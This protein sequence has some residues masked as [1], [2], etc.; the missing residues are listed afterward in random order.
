MICNYHKC[1]WGFA[2]LV[3]FQIIVQDLQALWFF[4]WESSFI[5]EYKAIVF[6]R[7]NSLLFLNCLVK[8]RCNFLAGSK[9]YFDSLFHLFCCQGHRIQMVIN[10][11]TFRK[12]FFND[13]PSIDFMASLVSFLACALKDE[14]IKIIH[15]GKGSH[16]F[17]EK[18]KV[19]IMEFFCRKQQLINKVISPMK[20]HDVGC[21][22]TTHCDTHT[23][24]FICEGLMYKDN[25]G[26][27]QDS[28]FT[29]NTVHVC[30]RPS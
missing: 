12:P 5:Y 26:C 24:F 20:N 15:Q 25:V 2:W 19:I 6:L 29:F 11:I 18:V 27:L 22:G 14:F 30:S 17:G 21:L 3:P 16:C 7:V 10:M 9:I 13:S 23:I 1:N 8:N 28:S 4:F